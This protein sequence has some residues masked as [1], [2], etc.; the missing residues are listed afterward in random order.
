MGPLP[1]G[2]PFPPSQALSQPD[3]GTASPQLPGPRL[4][5]V[6]QP[7]SL[8]PSFSEASLGP[9]IPVEGLLWASCLCKEHLGLPVG[10]WPQGGKGLCQRH[11]LH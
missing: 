2:L 9:K 11:L 4:P 6:E 8:F 5:Q 3:T 1:K 10:F 7:S